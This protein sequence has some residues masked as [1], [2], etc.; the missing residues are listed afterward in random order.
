MGGA[1]IPGGNLPSVNNS[2]AFLTQEI[3]PGTHTASGIDSNSLQDGAVTP[4][5]A[6]SRI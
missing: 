5:N 4:K 1:A 6:T 2:K 3:A